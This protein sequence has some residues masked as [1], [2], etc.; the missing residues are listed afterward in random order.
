MRFRSESN[1]FTASRGRVRSI[2]ACA[3]AALGGGR[4][5]RDL[6]RIADAGALV[7]VK[8]GVAAGGGRVEEP[9][10]VGAPEL[11]HRHDARWSASR[12]CRCR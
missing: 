8:L 2:V 1:G 4:E 3:D 6:R 10:V 7:G 11:A 12:S 5:E 9:D